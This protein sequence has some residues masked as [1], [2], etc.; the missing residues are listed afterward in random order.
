MMA[1]TTE[2]EVAFRRHG[3]AN[4]SRVVLYSLGSPMWATRFWWMVEAGCLRIV[5]G[6]AHGG[7]IDAGRRRRIGAGSGRAVSAWNRAFGG[8][9]AFR[10]AL[11]C[12]RRQ[13]RRRRRSAPPD[14]RPRANLRRAF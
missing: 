11:A 5:G 1:G 14:A 10:F 9:A 4:D 7:P 3:V 8:N 6:I 12:R 2:L 13:V